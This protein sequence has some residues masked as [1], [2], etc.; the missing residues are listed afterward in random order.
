MRYGLIVLL[1]LCFAAT[2]NCQPV[3]FRHYQVEDGLPNNT[4]FS[5]F[6]DSRG[7]M[8]FGTK[9]GLCR[10]DGSAFRAF[11]MPKGDREFVY[12]VAE[13]IHH[14][15]WTGTRK[16]LY[17]FDPRTETFTA[18]AAAQQGEVLDVIA[19]RQGKVWFTANLKLHCYDERSQT[20]RGYQS[21]ISAIGQGQDSSIWASSINGYLFRYN[22]AS[23]SFHC[24]NRGQPA[25]AG[26][27][28]RIYC[29][30]SGGVLVGTIRGLFLFD[31][32]TGD[33]RPLL[34]QP[35]QEKSVYVRDILHYS[36]N[37]YW[38]ASE[39]GIHSINLENGTIKALQQKDADPYSLS[40]NAAYTLFRDREGGIWC[41]TYFGGVN[42]YH[43][44]HSYFRKYFRDDSQY[45]LS[46]KAVREICA[47]N[48]GNL[49]IGTEDAGLNKL[50]PRTGKVSRYAFPAVVSSTNIHALLADGNELWVGTFQQ[51]LDVLDLR[52]GKRL[53]HYNADPQRNGLPSNFIISACKTK[54]GEVLLGTS[55]GVYRYHRASQRFEPAPGFPEHIYVFSLY[56]DRAGC[57]WAGTIG[58]GLYYHQPGTGVKGNMRY[59]PNNSNGISSNSICGIFED[60]RRQLWI[61]TE[62]GGLCRLDSSRRQLSR[63]N[64]T[65]GLPSDMI[66]KVL[67][68]S[69]KRLWISTS[70]GLA[71]HDPA[72]GDWK[73]YTKSHGLLTDQFNYNS[74]YCDSSGVLYFG[75][76][77]GLVS[78]RPD[79]MLPENSNPPVYI[80]SFQVNNQELAANSE[81]LRHSITFSDTVYLKYDQ[82]SFA[83][84]FAALTYISADMTQYAYRLDGLDK[85]WNY[86]PANRKVYFTDLSPGDYLFRVKAADSAETRLLVRIMPPWW[87]S[88]PA[89]LA[90]AVFTILLIYA[91]IHAYHHRQRI[92]HQRKLAIFEQ[93]KEKEIYKA[94]IEF[95][96]NVA[97]EIR[98]PLTLIKGPLEMV[99][100]E[101]GENPA[102]K[103][104][105]Q[106]IERN[107]ERLVALTGQLLDFRKTE[108]QDFSLSFVEADVTHLVQE[109]YLAFSATAQQKLLSFNIDLPDE[110]FKAFVDVEAFHKIIS[111]LI[112]NALKYAATRAV[113]TVELPD[114]Q[115]K[116]RIKVAN[117]GPLIPW[118]LREKIFEPFFRIQAMEQPGSGIGL[119]LARALAQLHSG[120]LRLCET[121]GQMNTFELLLPV[122]QQIEFKFGSAQEQSI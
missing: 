24:V 74:G 12:C 34:G 38:I 70:R 58:N 42:Y 9:E 16:G 79:A 56:E 67:E 104:S 96:T 95:F 14:T 73:V 25:L 41:G 10:F 80:T 4:V 61:S 98:T 71:L 76:V 48:S 37:E 91:L 92:R 60:S 27:V 11:N 17:E 66:Y 19:G 86:L 20:T 115:G 111:N 7:F 119:P 59:D 94:K 28:N 62:G 13:G 32:A 69:S 39:S 29:T 43:D 36:A 44:R 6:Q 75:S 2:G 46:G 106:N 72:T 83:I 53:R 122:H 93:Q 57:V 88:L 87:R 8:W 85:N 114:E 89:Y 97:H 99:I 26:T 30:P 113:I 77:K 108:H 40:D 116:F 49:W 102:V 101:V 33:Y 50:D 110:R 1:A 112:S 117:D 21:N 100:D 18:R 84:G 81:K 23:D 107:T 120:T 31:P 103:K 55:Q 5:V 3:Y 90:Y 35:L 52:T 109:N 121:E 105:L 47:D 68:D 45:S 82:S 65:V 64:T 118:Q 22:A 51:G 78:F 63:Y 54:K 15:L